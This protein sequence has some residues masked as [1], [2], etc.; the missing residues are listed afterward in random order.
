MSLARSTRP[1]SGTDGIESNA[2]RD[3]AELPRSATQ[4]SAKLAGGASISS[5]LRRREHPRE[6]AHRHNI[7]HQPC[8]DQQWVPLTQQATTFSSMRGA[9]TTRSWLGRVRSLL[10]HRGRLACDRSGL[11]GHRVARYVWPFFL[12]GPV[13]GSRIAARLDESQNAATPAG[14]YP[15]RSAFRVCEYAACVGTRIDLT[16][17]AVVG[18]TERD[19]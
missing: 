4:S 10:T 9:R 8:C 18:S 6:P 5:S 19:S 12:V 2:A 16:G 3:C 13:I 1:A 11:D 17:R 14:T 15:R 7:R